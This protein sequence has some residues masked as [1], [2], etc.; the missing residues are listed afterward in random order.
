[1]KKTVKNCEIGK[2]LIFFNALFSTFRM[3]LG[4]E[5]LHVYKFVEGKYQANEDIVVTHLTRVTI[6]DYK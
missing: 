3:L 2:N 5:N 6:N 1:M 4:L